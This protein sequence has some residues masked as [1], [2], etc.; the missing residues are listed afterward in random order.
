MGPNFGVPNPFWEANLPSGGSKSALQTPKL[1]SQREI[2]L[3]G[4]VK[5]DIFVTW[6]PKLAPQTT[7]PRVGRGG[8]TT[9]QYIIRLGFLIRKVSFCAGGG[10]SN[11]KRV[12]G[13][14]FRKMWVPI[15]RFR[16]KCQNRTPNLV[17]SYLRRVPPIPKSA[18][19]RPPKPP[20]WGGVFDTSQDGFGVLVQDPQEGS[21]THQIPN[22]GGG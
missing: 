1:P 20:S 2:S 8:G 12:P 18:L 11:V 6:D 5:S 3:S 17:L 16:K 4:G 9:K 7:L 15:P 21:Q 13:R 14:I 22:F 10:C 19:F